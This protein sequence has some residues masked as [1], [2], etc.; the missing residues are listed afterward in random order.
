[1]AIA[2]LA[3][4]GTPR[5]G[6][7][8][9]EYASSNSSA[10][11]SLSM[12]FASSMAPIKLTRRTKFI[13]VRESTTGSYNLIDITYQKGIEWCDTQLV[14]NYRSSVIAFTIGST[15]LACCIKALTTSVEVTWIVKCDHMYLVINALRIHVLHSSHGNDKQSVRH[16]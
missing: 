11:K 6:L 3:V 7:L 12:A 13:C 15:R 2:S 16:L 10:S 5:K 14:Q 9:S 4:K 1:M 8:V